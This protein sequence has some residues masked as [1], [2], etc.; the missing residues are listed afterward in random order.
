M[1][2]RPVTVLHD[3]PSPWHFL[4]LSSRAG[5]PSIKLQPTGLG[6]GKNR[7]ENEVILSSGWCA[8]VVELVLTVIFNF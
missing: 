2:R 6:N 1:S 7:Q 4:H 3:D 8:W 5:D